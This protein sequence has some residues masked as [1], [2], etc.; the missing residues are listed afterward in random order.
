[1]RVVVLI[2]LLLGAVARA[3]LPITEVVVYYTGAYEFV[4]IEGGRSGT[5]CQYTTAAGG[6]FWLAHAEFMCPV[7][8][9][10]PEDLVHAGSNGN[11]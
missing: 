4:V 11:Q 2:A 10:L 3:E 7:E 6:L 8:L 9:R 5:R 1:M